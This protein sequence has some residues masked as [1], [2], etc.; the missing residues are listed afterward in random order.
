MEYLFVIDSLHIFLVAS[1]NR[2][3]FRL[4]VPCNSNTFHFVTSLSVGWWCGPSRLHLVDSFRS[5]WFAS[6]DRA[7]VK[8]P[9]EDGSR[10]SSLS[11]PAGRVGSFSFLFF[12]DQVLL[13]QKSRGLRLQ[14]VGLGDVGDD[15][16]AEEDPQ[17]KIL[18]S[19]RAE[20][21]SH[22]NR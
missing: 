12:V 22:P 5:D 16:T 4:L 21:P 6:H 9:K 15:S 13:P 2:F 18:K 17:V 19:R 14:R 20:P 7:K 8:R 11:P 10:S 1:A 3:H